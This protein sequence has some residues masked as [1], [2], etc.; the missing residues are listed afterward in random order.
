GEEGEGT[1]ELM[2]LITEHDGAATVFETMALPPDLPAAAQPAPAILRR[3]SPLPSRRAVLYLQ[4]LNDSLV[5]EDLAAWY[6][7]RGFHFYVADLRQQLMAGDPAHS[8]TRRM[9]LS[10]C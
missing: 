9:R 10:D 7:E 2:G 6:T 5:P 1:G 3:Q 4:T 8:R